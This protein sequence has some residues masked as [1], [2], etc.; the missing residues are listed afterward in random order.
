MAVTNLG[1]RIRQVGLTVPDWNMVRRV[2]R[3]AFKPQGRN[4]IDS[5]ETFQ[6]QV[7]AKL[8]ALASYGM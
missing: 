4:V 8:Q 2:N 1:G 5:A 6:Q 3:E 7:Y